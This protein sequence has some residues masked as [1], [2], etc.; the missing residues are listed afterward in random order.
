MAIKR[1]L[2]TFTFIIVSLVFSSG[3]SFA[4]TTTD[5]ASGS[6][7]VWSQVS[8]TAGTKLKVL[9]VVSSPLKGTPT[10]RASG[11][12][13]LRKGVLS[14]NRVGKCR[15][16]VSV[17]MKNTGKVLRSSKVFVVS[18]KTLSVPE[19]QLTGTSQEQ[20]MQVV[21]AI[22]QKVA[23]FSLVSREWHVSLR[24]LNLSLVS[25]GIRVQFDPNEEGRDIYQITTAG[26]SVC[27]LWEY[28]DN[29]SDDMYLKPHTCAKIG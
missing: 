19:M 2:M 9:E 1:L 15:V 20:L 5:G 24:Q 11:V 17:K 21:R 16:S 27:F 10:Y 7:F 3:V 8:P 12:C 18:A 25:Y 28:V 14:F 22:E 4:L 23:V 13:S 29:I 26:Q 6:T